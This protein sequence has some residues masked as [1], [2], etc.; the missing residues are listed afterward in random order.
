MIATPTKYAFFFQSIIKFCTHYTF[1]VFSVLTLIYS[2]VV[3]LTTSKI[4]F[5]LSEEKRELRLSNF[6]SNQDPSLYC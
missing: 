2:D 4:M 6:T 3:R 1:L 5:T